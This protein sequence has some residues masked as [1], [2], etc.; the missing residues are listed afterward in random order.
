[1]KYIYSHQGMGDHIICNGLVRHFAEQIGDVAVFCKPQ[2]RDNMEWMYRDDSR[3]KVLAIG[4]DQDTV[5]YIVRNSLQNDT[6]L[7]GFQ[8]LWDKWIPLVSSF[9]EAFYKMV[10]V[11]F[12]YR[13][14][15]FNFLRD[16]EREQNAYNSVNP[17]NEPYI[18]LHGDIDR[19][20]VRSD[21]KIIENPTEFG[22]FDIIKIL[23]NAEEIHIMESS[24]KCLLCSFQF[25]KPKLFYHQYVR[26]YDKFHTS[27]FRG[28]YQ[29][30]N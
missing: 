28:E 14:T 30:I 18:F 15:K 12:E 17:T 13:F 20:K 22:I 23:E 9:D 29:E 2:Y 1:M 26:G 7:V 3:I 4:Q 19:S 21:L 10:N 5:N 11:P 24:I 8:E 27:Q 6:I 25:E 16:D